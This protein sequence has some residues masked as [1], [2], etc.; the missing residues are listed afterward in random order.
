MRADGWRDREGLSPEDGPAS[1]KATG[2]RGGF[3]NGKARHGIRVSLAAPNRG[4]V[5]R[6]E[7]GAL[8]RVCGTGTWSH[9]EE[10]DFGR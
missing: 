5:E 3:T 1:P 10:L 4:R 6:V 7:A 2:P 8:P 9:E